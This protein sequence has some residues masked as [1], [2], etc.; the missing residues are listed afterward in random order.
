MTASPKKAPE[1]T[2]RGFGFVYRLDTASFLA[3]AIIPYESVKCKYSL[4]LTF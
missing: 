3:D 4:L 2:L 1:V